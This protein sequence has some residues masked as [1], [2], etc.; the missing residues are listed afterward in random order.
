[1]ETFN[2]LKTIRIRTIT[3]QQVKTFFKSLVFHVWSGFPKATQTEINERFAIC[4]GCEMYHKESSQCM[5][6]GCNLSTKKIFLNK[7]AW[8][9]QQ[10]PL[11]K[12]LKIQR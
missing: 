1:M 9:D 10:C 7:L 6:C 12:W 2:L 11:N 3:F 4:T 8:A 5:M